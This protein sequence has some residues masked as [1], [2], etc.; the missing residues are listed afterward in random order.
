MPDEISD[1]FPIAIRGE[2]VERTRAER[3]IG[4]WIGTG[5]LWTIAALTIGAGV[6]ATAVG[7]ICMVGGYHLLRMCYEE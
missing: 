6:L 2:I 1:L 3:P 5:C 7:V 4:V